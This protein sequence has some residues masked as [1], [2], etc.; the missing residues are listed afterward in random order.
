M[1]SKNFNILH[2]VQFSELK[3]MKQPYSIVC[4]NSVDHH[5]LLSFFDLLPDGTGRQFNYQLPEKNALLVGKWCK[6]NFVMLPSCR[7]P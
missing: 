5:A 2:H 3:Y 6:I 1:N 4:N 7:L